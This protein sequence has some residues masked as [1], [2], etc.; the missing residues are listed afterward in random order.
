MATAVRIRSSGFCLA[1]LSIPAFQLAPG[2]HLCLHLPCTSESPAEVALVAALEGSRPVPGLEV[3]ARVVWAR[4]ASSPTSLRERL[5]PA[6][7]A[8]F[9]QRS[10]GLTRSEA[11]AISLE[12]GLRG[13][14]AVCRS[15]GTPKQLL[16][17]A[18]A[19]A[20]NAE[21]ILYSPVGLDPLG[22]DAV[23]A[24]VKAKADVCPAI[25]LSHAFWTQGRYERQC[26]GGARCV[27]V[28]VESGRA[29]LTASPV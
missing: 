12:L 26:P 16:G 5:W 19:W 24:A 3:T 20:G 7:V 4:P 13:E 8:G 2:D 14:D 10:A 17:L 22:R 21:A 11:R 23:F 15:P 18:A 1:G 6:T 28:T 29:E 9:L 25:H 27:D